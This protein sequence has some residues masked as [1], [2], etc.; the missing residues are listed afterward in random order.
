MPFQK[1]NKGG[2]GRPKKIVEAADQSLL[3]K[4]FDAEAEAMVIVNMI[5]LAS[6]ESK[7]AVPAATWLWDRKYG[8]LGDRS[9]NLNI[10]PEQ[11]AELSD[12]ELDQLIRKL[13]TLIR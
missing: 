5:T 12:N 9:T 4:L 8:K 13:S 1:G 2:P 11:L 3:E 7:A 6:T 10:T